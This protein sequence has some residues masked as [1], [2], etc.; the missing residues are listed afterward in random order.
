MSDAADRRAAQP[1]FEFFCR[2]KKKLSERCAIE[3]VTDG[4]EV[5]VRRGFGELVPGAH[6]L[7]VVTAVDAI[8]DEWSELL[9]NGPLQLDRQIRDATPCIELPRRRD[10]ARRT[11]GHAGVARTAV[12]ARRWIDGQ[13]E[14]GVNLTQEKPRTGVARDEIGVFADPAESGIACDRLLEDRSGVDVHA[15]TERTDAILDA[16]G[17]ILQGVTQDLVVVAPE[18][19]SGNVADVFRV[20]REVGVRRVARPIVEP[21]ADGTNRTGLE[22]RR[23]RAARAMTRHV[24]HIAMSAFLEPAQQ[25]PLVLGE[26]E[27]RD[28]ERR[29]SEPCGEGVEFASQRMQVGHRHVSSISATVYS[30]LSVE[31]RVARSAMSRQLDC[32]GQVD[33]ES[34]GLFGVA[35]VRALDM[36]TIASGISGYALM[37]RA[38]VSA[39]A[40]LRARWP[41]A[42]DVLVLCGGGN[43]GGDG[44]VVA[45]LAHAAGLSVRVL[46]T[47]G[48]ERLRGDAARAAE[49][50]RQSGVAIEIVSP[51]TENLS[52]VRSHLQRADVI[53]DGLLGIGLQQSVRAELAALIRETNACRRPILALDVPS[54]LC[55][56]TGQ[57]LGEAIRAQ[58]TITFIARKVGLWLGAGPEYAGDVVLDDLGATTQGAAPQLKRLMADA[59]DRALPPRHRAAHKGDFGHVLVIGGGEGMPGAARLAGEAALRTGAGRVTA[60]VAP[61]S[62]SAVASGCPELM[63]RG[64]SSMSFSSDALA[65]VDALA[66]GPGLGRSEWARMN[67]ANA[68]AAAR[69]NEIPVVLDADALNL[70]AEQPS[71]TLP[72]HTVLTP[73]P[74]EAARLL[75][76]TSAEIQ[77]DRL[78]ALRALHARY[79]ATVVLKGAGSLVSDETPWICDRGNP[80]MAAPGM[81]DVLTGI[82]VALIAQGLSTVEAAR[83]GVLLH[84]M[85]GDLAASG[86]DR[87]LLAS[88]VSAAVPQVIAQARCR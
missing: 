27:M 48:V 1:R 40:V 80:A 77:A 28:T 23:S 50:C 18:C 26:F 10:R 71:L 42:K 13:R 30:R 79:A 7:T 85:A 74:G 34:V 43:N 63:V 51:Y 83:I 49:D 46:A 44:Y 16:I 33:A 75:G 15:I 47:V 4:L 57:V 72:K 19:V 41:V 86:R 52:V 62:S 55:A 11:G 8:A 61:E 73:H 53:V 64:Q 3:S 65:T 59:L 58:V 37:S 88:E 22:F 60:W 45:R 68:L 32:A 36:A 76:C 29:K 21:Y 39:L 25:M 67:F 56:E 70:L 78:A 87:G 12:R 31:E 5:R 9:G 81:G 82:I 2:P 54:G 14:I 20:Q 6:E 84:A 24:M 17:E 69:A 35:A 66:I 38:G